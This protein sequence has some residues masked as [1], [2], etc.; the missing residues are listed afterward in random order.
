MCICICVCV[1]E[2]ANFALRRKWESAGRKLQ[3]WE[4]IIICNSPDFSEQKN[5]KLDSDSWCFVGHQNTR[6]IKDDHV[7][8]M[9]LFKKNKSAFWSHADGKNKEYFKSVNKS[10]IQATSTITTPGSSWNT[11]SFIQD[12]HH[13]ALTSWPLKKMEIRVCGTKKTFFDDFMMKNSK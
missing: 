6:S 1:S 9:L 7:I 4:K 13:T 3:G 11:I 8:R 5:E 2:E 12:R 10:K